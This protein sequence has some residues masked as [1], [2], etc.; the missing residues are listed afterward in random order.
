MIDILI[1]LVTLVGLG[2]GG[3]YY[4][5]GAAAIGQKC[6]MSPVVIG[7]TIV[8]IGTSLPEWAISVIAA[9]NEAAD[10]A[11]G[12]VVG[13]NICNVCIILGFASLVAPIEVHRR[14]LSATRSSCW[15]RRRC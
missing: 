5:T 6:G 14:S 1:I 3:H 9:F 2:I 13:S 4:V 11:V 8:A 12:N 10:L 15:L 7:A